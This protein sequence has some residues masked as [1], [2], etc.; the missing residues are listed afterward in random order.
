MRLEFITM[1]YLHQKSKKSYENHGTRVH[2]VIEMASE[3]TAGTGQVTK[4]LKNVLPYKLQSGDYLEYDLYWKHS[5]SQI[6]FDFKTDLDDKPKSQ[7][8]NSNIRDQNNVN[9]HPNTNIADSYVLNKWYHRVIPVP[10]ILIG[11][12]IQQDTAKL[13]AAQTLKL[14]L[15]HTK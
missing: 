3:T 4:E 5:N 10:D 9:S 14:F 1:R 6:A 2:D 8:K 7:F 15:A 11:T 13:E 12:T